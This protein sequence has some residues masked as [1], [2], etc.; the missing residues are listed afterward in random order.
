MTLLQEIKDNSFEVETKSGKVLTVLEVGDA[1][2][3]ALKYATD[4]SVRKI[5]ER[6]KEDDAFKGVLT[7][8][9]PEYLNI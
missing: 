2:F 3:I 9:Y 4:D 5:L 7:H 1:R 6:V 8:G